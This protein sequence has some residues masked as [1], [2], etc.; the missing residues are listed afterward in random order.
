MIT[1]ASVST[2]Q[3]TTRPLPL[4]DGL[5]RG[6]RD[7]LRPVTDHNWG[8]VQEIFQKDTATVLGWMDLSKSLPNRGRL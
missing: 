6:V 1:N 4:P 3:R 2:P 7:E 8:A 5:G